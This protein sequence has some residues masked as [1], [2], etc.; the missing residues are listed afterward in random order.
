MEN[1]TQKWTQSGHLSQNQGTFFSDFQN[2]AGE[3]SPQKISKRRTVTNQIAI[4]A[5]E[6]NLWR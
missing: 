5:I 3:A 1:L 2:T 6:K 4:Y